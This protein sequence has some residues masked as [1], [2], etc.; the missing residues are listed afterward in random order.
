MAPEA[1]GLAVAEALRA[2]PHD[3]EEVAALVARTVR[4]AV[5]AERARCVAE[6]RRLGAHLAADVLKP[7]GT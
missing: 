6:C 1:R 7:E 4:A 2:V 5:E 3:S